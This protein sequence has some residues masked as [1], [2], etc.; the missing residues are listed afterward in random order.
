MLCAAK[1]DN[2]PE[3]PVMEC[4]SMSKLVTCSQASRAAPQL[5]KTDK[6]T[7]AKGGQSEGLIEHL[8]RGNLGS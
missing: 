7:A 8:Q 2:N 1:I 6:H 4:S 5:Q 3:H